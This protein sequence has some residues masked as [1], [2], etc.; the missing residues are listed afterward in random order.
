MA[1]KIRSIRTSSGFLKD[2]PIE[3]ADGL[4]CIIGARG[5]C[6]STVV[7]TI[8]FAF[9]CD[10]D[11]VERV[12]LAEVGKSAGV[13]TTQTGLIR[14]TL[15]E[16][17]VRCE[18]DDLG[19][20]SLSKLT[21]ERDLRSRPRAFREGVKELDEAA[22]F[23]QIE[24][25]SQG[26]LQRFAENDNM[27]L[28][29]I[30]RPHKAAIGDLRRRRDEKARELGEIGPRLREKRA[31]IEARKTKVQTLGQLREQ[32]A[33]LQSARPAL[34]EELD[35]ER[36]AFQSRK[37]LL[38]KARAAVSVKVT[39]AATL[40][41]AVDGLPG[42]RE[43]AEELSATSVEEAASLAENLLAF[44]RFVSRIGRDLTTFELVDLSAPL[45]VV[46][47][48]F[49]RRNELYYRLRQDQQDV[50]ESLK[51]EDAIRQQISQLEKL[52]KELEEL[53]A[54]EQEL[55]AARKSAR[56]A[57]QRS[58][59]QIYRLRLNEVDQINSQHGQV[60]LLALQ[61]GARSHEYTNLLAKL[62]QGSRLRNQEDVVRAV[63]EKVRPSDL[64][65]IVEA[66]D[67]Q[68]LSSLLS[69]DLSQMARLTSFLMDSDDLYQLEGVVFDDRLEITL[70]D[71]D[72]AKPVSQLSKGQIA[73][74]LLPLILRPAAYPLV[75]D[76]PEDDLDNRFIYSTLVE[77]I[78][79]LKSQR[80][81]VFVTHNANIPV[82]G[83]A[84]R[85]VVMHMESPVRAGPPLCGSVDA[86]KTQ[87]LNLLEGG[88]DAFKRRQEKYKDLLG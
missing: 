51:R 60:V 76:Q 23:D 28:E 58:G 50:N 86:V 15:E 3:L 20:S 57:V 30:D 38:D 71:G 34:S 56:E 74:A 43:M 17:S 48:E 59:D 54:E 25:Y 36:E 61:Q 37:I 21:I 24:I 73:T 16:G 66:V 45:V 55:I 14:A 26:D 88:A 67:S 19:S 79:R 46:Q 83:E 39:A 6:K 29:L 12:L 87:I 64:V 49:E 77:H 69:R 44:E 62:L 52:G 35:R 47:E 42:I 65:D 33:A 85:V 82:L 22:L 63:A 75:F 4:T 11:R 40:R 70:Y 8:R 53:R 32:L 78:R 81:I 84:D 1:I 2:A 13:S 41:T 27:R 18:I 10:R 68:R 9:D 7:E 80:Q 31:E 5:T 72:V